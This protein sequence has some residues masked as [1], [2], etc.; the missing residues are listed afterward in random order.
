LS[1]S[2]NLPFLKI[3]EARCRRGLVASDVN[4]ATPSASSSQEERRQIT[5]LREKFWNLAR[6]DQTLPSRTGSV[7]GAMLPPAGSIVTASDSMAFRSARTTASA[8]PFGAVPIRPRLEGFP[9]AIDQSWY[10]WAVSNGF[11]PSASRTIIPSSSSY[12]TAPALFSPERELAARRGSSEPPALV[13]TSAMRAMTSAPASAYGTAR[14]RTG[15]LSQ[16]R[17]P[18]RRGAASAGSDSSRRASSRRVLRAAD[19]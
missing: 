5:C 17:M 11:S 13:M 3:V 4:Q 19:G 6:G 12:T 10:V 1:Q 14:W 7:V 15:G 8:S 18:M 9:E 16:P 2:H